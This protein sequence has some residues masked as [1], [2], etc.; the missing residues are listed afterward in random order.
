MFGW[1]IGVV[2]LRNDKLNMVQGMARE[3]NIFI[4]S[5]SAKYCFCFII[6][7][8]LSKPYRRDNDMGFMIA[9]QTFNQ[10]SQLVSVLTAIVSISPCLNHLPQAFLPDC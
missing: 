8:N 5:T 3:E 7:Y 2:I 9:A 4:T 6:I 10:A 1:E